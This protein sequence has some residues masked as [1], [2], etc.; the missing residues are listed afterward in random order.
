MDPAEK[1]AQS[2]AEARRLMEEFEAKIAESKGVVEDS[3]RIIEQSHII[4]E[5]AKCATKL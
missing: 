1:L 3:R 2:L 5:K 4:L